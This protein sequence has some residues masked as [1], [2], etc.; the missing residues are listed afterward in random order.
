M[1]RQLPT[2]ITTKRLLQM[3]NNSLL[4]VLIMLSIGGAW[5]TAEYC[6]LLPT[7]GQPKAPQTTARKMSL[8]QTI[9]GRYAQEF[10]M[11]RD[12]ATGHVPRERL[13]TA[14]RI[15]Q[16]KRALMAQAELAIPIYW[17]ERGPNNVGGRTR[18]LLIDANDATGQTVWAA[19]VSGGLWRTS[20]IQAAAP[21][22]TLTDD[23]F[24]NMAITTIAQDPS[25]ANVLYFGTGEQGLA[26]GVVRGMGIWRSANGGAT[27]TLLPNTLPTAFN[28]TFQNVNKVVVANNGTVYA[29]TI[30]G[31]RR[32]IDGGQTWTVMAGLPNGDVR[33][34]EIAADGDLFVGIDG[35]GVFRFQNPTWT[36]LGAANGLPAAGGTVEIA[37]APG[38]ANT[39]YAAFES[40][41]GMNSGSCLG[42][43]QSTDGGDNFVFR[44]APT[45][46]VFGT[47]CWYAFILAVDPNN[48]NR[49][50]AGDRDLLASTDGAATWTSIGGIHS[51]HHAITYRP[52]SSDEIVFG[53]DG[54]VYRTTNGSNVNPTLQAKNNGYNVTQF[55]ANA[56]HPNS[57]SNYMLGGTQDNG[58]PQ[59]N[60]AGVVSTIEAPGT[61][62]DGAFCFIDQDNPNIQLAASQDRHFYASNNG[63]ASFGTVI[64]TK[65]AALFI[66]P[67]EYDNANDILYFSDN[68][69]TLGRMT[70]VGAAN[71]VVLERIA[72]LGGGRISAIATSPATNNR[73]FVGT[74]NGNFV[75]IDNAHLGT[76]TTTTLTSPR[77]AYISC[78][79]VDPGNEA[80]LIATCSNY[81]AAGQVFESIDGGTTWINLSND[82]PDMP[83]RWAMFH[84]FDV[85]KLL[86]A[87]ELGVW[88][89]DNLQGTN[90]EWWPTNNFGLANVRVDMLQYRPSDHLV[91]AATHGRGM[92][93]TDYFTMLNTC[94]PTL[95]ISGAVAAGIYMAEDFITSDGVIAPGRKVIYHAGD[96][97]RLLPNFHAQ[98][99]SDFWALIEPC[100][101]GLAAAKV[102]PQNQ[103]G[104]LLPRDQANQ[105]KTADAFRQLALRCYP[106]PAAYRLFVEYDLPVEGN[107]SLYIRDIQ[108][109]LIETIASAAV[110]RA[111]GRYQIELDAQDYQA[112]IYVL[113]LQS[114]Q[115]TVTERFLVAR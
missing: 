7:T 94:V 86:L 64:P 68:I 25:N 35:A 104:D 40:T 110:Q 24:A 114:A 107:Y 103:G 21:T 9:A 85:D 102:Q 11:T 46:A 29:A 17:Q 19:G 26:N 28:N 106:N 58:T 71:T 55:Y 70:G 76:F 14:Y 38:D 98:A 99:G 32:S 83:V 108:G 47:I 105:E 75:R 97:V 51:D 91:A 92:Y 66:T 18:G 15:A 10:L 115:N 1:T 33:D 37:C 65:R 84:P 109:R 8:A 6:G 87:T 27:W 59:F 50:W 100:G 101:A 79:V 80:H 52:G 53:C 4:P 112:G 12:P 56:I 13:L 48:T 39:L 89:T 63:G 44:S 5:A 81:G 49:V 42:V 54:G 69:D 93:T 43:Y 36:Q 82:L 67:A 74:D 77:N 45:P 20:N 78:I 111:A 61:G 96:Y 2:C 62:G 3:K 30:Q 31:L 88:S 60:A 113:T 57:G 23:F 73:L 95:N 90:T 41:G 34:V 16:E 22:W 72:A